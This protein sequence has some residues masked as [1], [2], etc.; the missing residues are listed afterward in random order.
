[1]RLVW[2][3]A[4]FAC[5]IH[6]ER[7]EPVNPGEV[8]ATL[9][10]RVFGSALDFR[11]QGWLLY[12]ADGEQEFTDGFTAAPVW[13][14]LFAG[15]VDVVVV[16]SWMQPADPVWVQ[17]ELG[18]QVAVRIR[19]T[20]DNCSRTMLTIGRRL[21]EQRYVSLVADRFDERGRRVQ[22][23]V[24]IR[25]TAEPVEMV[26]GADAMRAEFV[27]RARLSVFTA[28]TSTWWGM[29]SGTVT[30]VRLFEPPQPPPGGGLFSD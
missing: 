19:L 4:T 16:D 18:Q 13:P 5:P 12:L 17:N 30:G 20:V 22:R 2:W 7:V 24:G 3:S 29:R 25:C 8:T 6:V 14:F 11:E 28:P 27:P 23:V 1:M 26:V 10:R 9:L 15:P 21:A